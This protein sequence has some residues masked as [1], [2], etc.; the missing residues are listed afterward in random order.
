MAGSPRR[1]WKFYVEDAVG[2][3]LGDQE[4][5]FEFERVMTS[6]LL[7]IWALWPTGESPIPPGHSDLGTTPGT[8][9]TL[10]NTA[11]SLGAIVTFSKMDPELKPIGR[12]IKSM[13][14]LADQLCEDWYSNFNKQFAAPLGGLYSNIVNSRSTKSRQKVI[15]SAW[16]DSVGVRD[17]VRYLCRMHAID[18]AYATAKS[19]TDAIKADVFAR[20][21]Y[22]QR[23][24]ETQI[25]KGTIESI[26]QDGLPTAVLLYAFER[27][28]PGIVELDL[29]EQSFL[30]SLYELLAEPAKMVNVLLYYKQLVSVLRPIMKKIWSLK[31]WDI[32]CITTDVTPTIQDLVARQES[33]NDEE[34][35]RLVA[36]FPKAK[37]Q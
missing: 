30:K 4:E 36:L 1:N 5:E 10:R 2:L 29:S 25:S 34:R 33:F 16:D 23:K 32:L 15:R 11:R 12:R 6:Y 7:F 27:Q 18:P 19:L 22:R 13:Q 31:R 9:L 21:E 14:A 20:V 26:W 24:R 8:S 17:C 28:L 3:L 37:W 35:S